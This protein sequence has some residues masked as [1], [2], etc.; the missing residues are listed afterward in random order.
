MSRWSTNSAGG[1]CRDRQRRGVGSSLMLPGAGGAC[2]ASWEPMQSVAAV[3][4][5]HA[6]RRGGWSGSGT[7]AIDAPPTRWRARRVNEGASA[8][9]IDCRVGA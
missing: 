4:A 7:A 3:V 9:E 8:T 6:D 2:V 1:P 5:A